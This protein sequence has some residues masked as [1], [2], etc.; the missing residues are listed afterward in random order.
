MDYNYFKAV[1]DDVREVIAESWARTK[2][3]CANQML[4]FGRGN[5]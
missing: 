1:C 2:C 3:R 4:F 5:R